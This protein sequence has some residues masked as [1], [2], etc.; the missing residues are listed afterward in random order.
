M[1]KTVF[2]VG[3]IAAS[4]LLGACAMPVLEV[5]LPTQAQYNAG[6]K[7]LQQSELESSRDVVRSEMVPAVNRVLP[8]IRNSTMNV[9]RDLGLSQYRC[10]LVNAA[11]VT[12][13]LD[14][15]EINAF[16]D[17]E[18]NIAINGGLV[19]LMGTDDEIAAVL[20]H[21][22]AHVM[23]GHVDKAVVNSMFGMLLG[24]GM[25]VA[26]ESMVPT[27]NPG[28]TINEWQNIGQQTGA[29]VYSP[30]M[31]IEADRT[32]VY[33]LHDAG[34]STEGMRDAI[35]RM[36]RTAARQSRGSPTQRVGFLQTH[37][38]N[39]RRIAHI[40]SAIDAVRTGI[41]LKAAP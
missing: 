15:T 38:S 39:D 11:H 22:F 34:F 30:E 6:I 20:A 41:K 29:T 16:A 31:E 37:P 8:R 33:I 7:A 17:L 19:S 35:V 1:G 10:N 28:Q 27:Q 5:P 2:C 9:C 36:H 32:A 25:G 3:A 12:V 13:I 40:V 24:T 23:Y 4:M 21:E 14:D 18:N 26:M